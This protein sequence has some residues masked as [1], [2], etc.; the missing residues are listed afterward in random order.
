M[1]EIIR[2][3]TGIDRETG[4]LLRGR[5][6]LVQSLQHIWMT[7]VE[8]V[9]M[10]LSYGSSL[11]SFLAEDVTPQLVLDFY[12]EMVT[13]AHRWEPEARI[14][15]LQLVYLTK[16]GKLGLEYAGTYYPEG[17]FDNYAIS[18]ALNATYPL[19]DRERL[20]RSVA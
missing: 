7:R 19:T 14:D 13:T 9:V 18:E 3:R 5:P 10:L 8:S 11:R 15:R 20:T 17:R 12:R 6:H 4:A 16:T 2:Y 1:A